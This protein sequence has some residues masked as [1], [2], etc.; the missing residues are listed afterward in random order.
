[1]ILNEG[2]DIMAG[3]VLTAL[4]LGIRIV[5]F[6]GLLM[7]LLF[8]PAGTLRWTEGWIFLIFYLLLI[9]SFGLWMRIKD[10]EL[11]KERASIKK[12]TKS[13]D[14]IIIAAYLL[15][16]TGMFV[17]IGF[18]AVRFRWSS[19]PLWLKMFGFAGFFPVAY[20]FFSVTA[21]NTFLSGTVRIQ[22][23]R[24]HR[25][26]TSGPYGIVRHPMYVAVIL[27]A[28]LIPLSLGSYF[29]L[30]GSTLVAALFV[31]RTALEDKTLRSELE[32]YKE[33]TDEVRFRLLPGI[34]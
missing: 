30:I 18:D 16:F 25:V 14:R 22:E 28:F 26:C 7:V 32:G 9:L 17:L 34:W 27:F 5:Y 6:V 21:H 33:Y 19:V 31:L 13:F 3:K 10:P 8:W 29:G 23:E 12:G 2:K 24:G 15:V 20:I 4:S 1:L 11:Y